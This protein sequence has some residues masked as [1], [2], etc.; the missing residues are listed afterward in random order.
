VIKVRS[1]GWRNYVG[2][3]LVS[4]KLKSSRAAMI[5]TTPNKSNRLNISK[6]DFKRKGV[7]VAVGRT[8]RGMSNHPNTAPM[9]D[10]HA[11]NLKIHLQCARVKIPPLLQDPS[12]PVRKSSD[13]I[14]GTYMTNPLIVPHAQITEQPEGSVR[15]AQIP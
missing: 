11:R 9:E 4:A 10:M 7:G 2:N 8:A 3:L 5:N 6:A 14:Y 13:E 12:H 1:K 15:A